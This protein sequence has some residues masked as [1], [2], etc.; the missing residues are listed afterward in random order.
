MSKNLFYDKPE[1]S[2]LR[3]LRNEYGDGSQNYR[4]NPNPRPAKAKYEQDEDDGPTYVDEGS[5]EIISKEKYLEMVGGQSKDE[6]PESDVKGLE[7]D[8]QTDL[9]ENDVATTAGNPKQSIAEIGGSKK[10]KQGRIIGNDATPNQAKQGPSLER[11]KKKNSKKKIKL[12]FE[13]D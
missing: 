13:D 7:E 1:P 6:P 8:L 4:G 9:V 3:K 2:F 10:R 12:S 5:N 11:R